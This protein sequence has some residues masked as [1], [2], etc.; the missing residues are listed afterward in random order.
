MEYLPSAFL[1]LVG[2][3]EATLNRNKKITTCQPVV[4]RQKKKQHNKG[5]NDHHSPQ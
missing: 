1:L 3:S 5:S 4:Q 2:K